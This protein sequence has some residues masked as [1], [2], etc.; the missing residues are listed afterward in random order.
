M[1]IEFVKSHGAGN[2][3]VLIED[4]DDQIGMLDGAFVAV[5]CD[6]HQGVGGDGLIRIAP[7]DE[8]DFFM[9]Y[10]N[11]DGGVAEMC[12]N[13][14]RCLAKY[15]S[16]R[17]IIG[18]DHLRVDTRAGIKHLDL[19]RNDEGLVDRVRVDMGPPILARADI[20]VAGDGDPLHVAVKGFEAACVSMG[21]PHAVVVIPRL[22][23]IDVERL[24]PAI[25]TDETFPAKTNVEFTEVLSRD[26]VRVRVWERGVGETQACGTG[27]CATAVAT[28]LLGLTE[29]TVGVNMPG[30]RLDIDWTDETTFLTGPVVEVFTGT[31][32]EH[33]GR[34]LPAPSRR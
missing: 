21:N 10:Y 33:I 7:S 30:G 16:D 18:G 23:D 26:E 2:D 32:D 14:I 27:A 6:R 29:R 34:K 8:A 15:V 5:V 13:G 9:D 31:L 3:F 24:G 22:A 12:G 25:E 1:P 20:P 19:Y 28:N 11:A 17:G 4:L